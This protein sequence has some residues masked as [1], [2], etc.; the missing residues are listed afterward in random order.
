MRLEIA[1]ASAPEDK[2]G[3]Q[4][5]AQLVAYVAGPGAQ[6]G[7][8]GRVLVLCHGYPAAARGV[9]ASGH[10]YPQ[11]AERLAGESGWSVVSFNFRGT[12]ESGGDFSLGGWMQD[13][14][15]VVDRALCLPGAAG[16]W[17]AGFSTGG[18]LAVCAAGEDERIRGV[19]SF[20]APA[21]F[22]QWAAQPQKLIAHSRDLGVIRSKDFPADLEAWARALRE[23][24]P[25]SLVGKIPPRP[26]LIVH[27]IDDDVVAPVDARALAEA[28]EGGA[29]LRMLT[30]ADH[31]LR[32]DP[33]AV[34]VLVGWMERQTD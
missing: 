33:R 31:R 29:E 1:S 9:A 32:H 2:V 4:S 23:L 16:V 20:A 18:A 26:V 10:T 30:G 7:P 13:L 21:D 34:A 14:R 5:G 8:A 28:T 17:L 3:D 11:L 27:G 15:A 25:V 12:G 19:A 6:D 22:D 24:R